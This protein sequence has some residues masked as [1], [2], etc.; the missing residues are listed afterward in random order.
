[1][2]G[3]QPLRAALARGALRRPVNLA[4]F[5]VCAALLGFAVYAQFDL[6]L[7]PCPLCIFQRIGIASIGVLFLLATLHHPRRW[8]GTVYAALI[9]IAALATL[10]VAARQIYLQH[11][12]PGT[13]P[14]CGAPLS[15]MLQFMSV[16]DVIR[17]VLTGSGECGI[18]NWTFLGLA[19][20]EWVLLWALALGAIGVLVNLRAL[21]PADSRA[22]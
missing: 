16:T 21:R 11:L 20:S 3:G 5:L 22:G 8:G 10:A 6:H 9:G 2:S 19:M 4:G 14:S 7:D 13:V 1:V 15:V 17:K 12:P 18:V